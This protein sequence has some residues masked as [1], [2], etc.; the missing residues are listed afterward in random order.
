MMGRKVP[1]RNGGA[2]ANLRE[3]MEILQTLRL[4]TPTA[5]DH[6]PAHSPEYIQKKRAEGHG[7]SNL[8]D[9]V[10]H[11]QTLR[12]PT[13]TACAGKG[14]SEASLTRKDGG[15]RTGDRIDHALFALSLHIRTTSGATDDGAQLNPDFIEFMMNWPIG[16]TSLAPLPAG[17]FD[18]WHTK[19]RA[20]EWFKCQPGVPGQAVKV[21]RR[22]ERIKA[23][24]N[25]Q[26]PL[27]VKMAWDFLS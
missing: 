20:G 19:T 26:V 23:A 2:P 25:G 13:P 27:A 15:D 11:M 16:W 1:G 21:P 3:H 6:Y 18:D 9:T 12:L 4:P 8:N 5:R 22:L 10:A 24:G 14:S 17:R 7:M